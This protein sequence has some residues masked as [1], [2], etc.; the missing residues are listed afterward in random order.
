MLNAQ[1]FIQLVYKALLSY[2]LRIKLWVVAYK[3]LFIKI[4]EKSLKILTFILINFLV[5]TLQYLLIWN[6]FCPQKVEKPSLKV[7]QKPSYMYSFF[8][9]IKKVLGYI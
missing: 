6:L 8:K 4:F 5:Q 7:A 1:F 2:T 9:V 3:K